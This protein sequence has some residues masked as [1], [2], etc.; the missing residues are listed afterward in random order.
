MCL[1]GD[2]RLTEGSVLADTLELLRG[3]V[4]LARAHILHPQANVNFFL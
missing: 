1:N 3:R 2:S 4:D